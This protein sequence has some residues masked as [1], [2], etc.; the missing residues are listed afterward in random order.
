MRHN[1]IKEYIYSVGVVDA[2]MGAIGMFNDIIGIYQFASV[3]EPPN[4]NITVNAT[5]S[6]V[7][8][9]QV[10]YILLLLVV[11]IPILYMV[12]KHK[13]KIIIREQILFDN[14]KKD[15]LIKDVQTTNDKP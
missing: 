14:T 2:F 5:N 9:I 13:N 15:A 8:I 11:I 12:I 7:V 4:Q 3:D 1:Y 6:T 10:E